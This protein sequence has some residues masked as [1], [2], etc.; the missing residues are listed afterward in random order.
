MTKR[1]TK[2]RRDV[3]QE[4][5]DNIIAALESGVAPW[6]CPMDQTGS[7]LLPQNAATGADYKGINT[8]NLW[9]TAQIKGYASNRWMTFKQ[10]KD[11]GGM[12]RK[13]EK[14][15]PGIFYKTLEKETGETK[16]NGDPETTTIP[17]L[18]SFAL[19]NLDQIDGLEDLHE[20]NVERER[21]AF[22]PIEAGEQLMAACGVATNHGGARAFY[23]PATDEI[24][25]PDRDR[26]E[27]EGDYYAVFA[28][29]LTH[30]TKHPTRCDRKPYETDIAKGAYA[31]EELVAELGA[32]FTVAHIGL[33]QPVTNHDS[34]IASWL[35]VLKDD[36]RCIFKAAAKAQKAADWI[37]GTLDS[38]HQKEAA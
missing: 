8:I 35:S 12:V 10:A 1:N 18:R 4:I 25:M 26:F 16:E 29:E 9:V 17:M 27:S 21:F 24:T 37:L 23:R 11:A 2:A 14:S 33:P 19:F 36:K 15:T 20:G 3:C 34:Y 31:F 5:T 28:H 13:G 7:V 30:A 6:R 22:T 32:L 38:T